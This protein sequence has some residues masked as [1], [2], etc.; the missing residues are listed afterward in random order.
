MNPSP[1]ELQVAWKHPRLDRWY[2]IDL[3]TVDW[4]TLQQHLE[5][6]RR[7][8]S[9][10]TFLRHRSQIRQALSSLGREDMVKKIREQAV[11]RPAGSGERRTLSGDKIEP[12]PEWAKPWFE[13]KLAQGLP[14]S[15]L[16]RY[17]H[18]LGDFQLDISR[19][20]LPQIRTRLAE[21]ATHYKPGTL[22]H[23][24]IVVK[25]VL[26]ELGREKEA[27]AI[28]LPKHGEPRVV[29]YS[30]EDIE[31]LLKACKTLRDRL[32]VEILLETGGRRGELYNMRIKD[33]QFDE[34]SPVIWLRG[35]TGTR[36][37]RVFNCAE[38]LKR[39]LEEHPDR[40]NAEAKFWLNAFGE[41]LQYQGF[42]KVIHRIGQRGLGRYIYPHGFRHTAATRDVKSYTDR[43]M[44]IRHGWNRADMV[45][46][47]AHLTGRDVDEKELQLRGLKNQQS[48]HC[49]NCNQENPPVA[50]YCMKCGQILLR[51][52]G[53]E[54]HG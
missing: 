38:D 43:E 33:V 1:N 47:Y 53:G 18:D 13:G 22:R 41:P 17:S 46:V 31:S 36:Q 11:Q 50:T 4:P 3:Q 51:A 39:Y 30:Q 40:L 14:M 6:F 44:M 8:R 19:S 9:H 49:A 24:A 45:G 15:S 48:R 21:C 7:Q 2:G 26:T 54:L 32:M 52:N 10:D 16:V 23:I 37:R 25:Q 35:K 27:K 42:Y 29:V 5:T 34:Y 28:K 20:T 12:V